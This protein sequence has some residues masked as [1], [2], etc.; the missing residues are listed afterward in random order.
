MHVSGEPDGRECDGAGRRSSRASSTPA[1]KS[2]STA[3]VH[4][5]VVLERSTGPRRVDDHDHAPTTVDDHDDRREPDHG[6]GAERRRHE[7]GP[8]AMPR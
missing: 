6:R 1:G 8:D 7:R 3:A 2:I 4:S 5:T